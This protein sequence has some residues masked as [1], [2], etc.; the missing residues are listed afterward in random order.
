MFQVNSVLLEY[1]MQFSYFHFK[2]MYRFVCVSD[3]RR[4]V[5]RHK[6]YYTGTH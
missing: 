5:E 2:I 4:S 1:V 6:A 3:I